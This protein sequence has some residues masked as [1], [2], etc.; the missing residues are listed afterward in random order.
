MNN[1]IAGHKTNITKELK[2]FG[3]RFGLGPSAKMRT[4]IILKTRELI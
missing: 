4:P 2:L 1:I 3:V